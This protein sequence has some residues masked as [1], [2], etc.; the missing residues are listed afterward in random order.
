VA[1]FCE[2]VLKEADGVLSLIRVHDSVMVTA[3]SDS[4]RELPEGRI[5]VNFVLM[6]KSGDAQGRHE[7]KIRVQQ[8]SGLYLDDI[9]ADVVFEGGAR[10]SNVITELALDAIEGT[11][12]FEVY[13]SERELTR[14][15]LRV[16]YRRAP[17]G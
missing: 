15:P 9:L 17:G 5:Q 10:G 8:P 4:P 2:K 12:W 1:A 11:Y 6:F 13:V 3:G 14:S 7:L 16:I